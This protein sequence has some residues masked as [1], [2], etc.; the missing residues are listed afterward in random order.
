[1]SVKRLKR[2]HFQ[3]LEDKIAA[4]LTPWMGKH[5]AAPGR[6][7]LVK[8]VIT[9][10][11]IYYMTALNLPVEVLKKIDALRRA[12]LWAGCD[13]VTGGKCK[14]NWAQVCMPKLHGGLGIL[15]LGKFAAALRLRWLWFN[16]QDPLK[17]WSGLGTPCDNNDRNIFASASKVLVGD[18][19]RATFW[20]SAWLDGIRPKDIAPKIYD[21]SNK[22][23]CSVHKA[24]L[25]GYWISQVKVA[26]ITSSEHIAQ[27]AA[28][29]ER[30]TH[31]QLNPDMQDSITWKFTA[32]G[33]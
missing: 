22:K 33:H 26:S 24:L 23:N 29:W 14:V 11:A 19:L 5:V 21:I 31:I 10:I 4:Q 25:N 20:E 8:S 9:A 28:L 1:M 16:W 6:M 27:F 32:D 2:I 30:L 18:G 17:P 15:N 7:V 3:P 12:Y 13:K